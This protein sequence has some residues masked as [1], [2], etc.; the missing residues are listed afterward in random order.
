MLNLIQHPE[1]IVWI[2][3]QVRNDKLKGITQHW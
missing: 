2:P 1:T 3:Y